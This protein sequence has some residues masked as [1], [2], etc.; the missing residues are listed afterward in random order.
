MNKFIK[1]LLRVR[2]SYDSRSFDSLLSVGTFDISDEMLSR[3]DELV[4]TTQSILST[5]QAI[6]FVIRV[7]NVFVS[8][9]EFLN[10]YDSNPD[11]FIS[12][13]LHSH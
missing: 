1:Y 2:T 10:K 6:R 11:K 12:F 7:E 5:W 3:I 4:V 8:A 9:H 13:C